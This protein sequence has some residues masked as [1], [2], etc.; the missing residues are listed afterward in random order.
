M[1]KNL[2]KTVF[3]NK[4][5]KIAIDSKQWI[6]YDK[7]ENSIGFFTRP[8]SLLQRIIDREFVKDVTKKGLI[9]ASNEISLLKQRVKREINLILDS[10][11][12]AIKE[13]D[14]DEA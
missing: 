12:E 8:E 7:K 2:E 6:L 3:E 10:I 13:G 14:N 9:K 1:N 4:K 5:I 11:E